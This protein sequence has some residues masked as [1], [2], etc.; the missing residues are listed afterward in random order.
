MEL[1]FKQ[2]NIVSKCPDIISTTGHLP[3]PD[4]FYVYIYIYIYIIGKNGMLAMLRFPCYFHASILLAIWK[5][6]NLS[7]RLVDKTRLF[8]RGYELN[9]RG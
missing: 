9:H 3:N 2:T 7:S 4:G 8:H 6:W 1:S 5:H